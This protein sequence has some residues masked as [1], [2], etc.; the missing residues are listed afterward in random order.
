MS[1]HSVHLIGREEEEEED[2]FRQLEVDRDKGEIRSPGSRPPSVIETLLTCLDRKLTDMSQRQ[3]E[4]DRRHEQQLANISQQQSELAQQHTSELSRLVERLERVETSIHGSARGSPN[5]G[6]WTSRPEGASF[7]DAAPSASGYTLSQPNSVSISSFPDYALIPERNSPVRFEPSLNLRRSLRLLGK[8]RPDYRFL[9]GRVSTSGQ[10]SMGTMWEEVNEI[11]PEVGEGS[12]SR[13]TAEMPRSQHLGVA[14]EVAA[15]RY[16]GDEDGMFFNP[17]PNFR[18]VGFE[19]DVGLACASRRNSEIGV[20]RADKNINNAMETGRISSQGIRIGQ[21]QTFIPISYTSFSQPTSR[22]ARPWTTSVAD[23]VTN[24][25]RSSLAG[26][27]LRSEGAVK[28]PPRQAPQLRHPPSRV[29]IRPL[30]E[31]HMDIVLREP[32]TTVTYATLRYPIACTALEVSNQMSSMW[33]ATTGSQE[34]RPYGEDVR[35]PAPSTYP[36]CTSVRPNFEEMAQTSSYLSM[37]P[38]VSTATQTIDEPAILGSQLLENVA[39]PPT[40]SP[41]APPT[42][43]PLEKPRNYIKLESYSGQTPLLPFLRRFEVCSRQNQWSSSDRLNHLLCSLKDGASQL[44]WESGADEIQSAEDL[45]ERLQNRY[46]TQ[47]QQA[48]FRVQLSARRQRPG[49]DLAALFADIQRLMAL[50]YPGKSVHSETIAIQAYLGAIDDREL[51]LKVSER[52][53]AQLQE[54]YK[55]SLRLQAYKQAENDNNRD[56]PRNRGRVHAVGVRDQENSNNTAIQRLERE[57]KELKKDLRASKPPLTNNCVPNYPPPPPPAF[58]PRTSRYM[59]G[60]LQHWRRQR[61]SV[62]QPCPQCGSNAHLVCTYPYQRADAIRAPPDAAPQEYRP[63]PRP[64]FQSRYVPG[65]DS[66]YLKVALHGKTIFALLDSGS[67]TSLCPQ[68]LIRPR[69]VRPSSQS[70]IAANGTIINVAGESELTIKVDNMTFKVP[71]LIT[72]QLDD[73]I[74]GLGWMQERITSWNFKE[75]WVEMQGRRVNVHFRSEAGRCRRVATAKDVVVP[76]FSEL[77]VEAYAILPN[78]KEKPS[79]WATKASL[80]DTG[81]IVAGSL[82][83][84][85]AVDLT[86]RV[87]NPTDKA[88]QL[89]RGVRCN[90]EKVTVVEQ[91][92]KESQPVRCANIVH[93]EPVDA[94]AVLEPLWRNIAED[95]PDEIQLK[96]RNLLLEHQKAFSLAEWDLGFTDILQHEIDTGSEPPVRQALRRQPLMQLPLIDEQVDIMLKQGLIEKSCSDWASNV[97]IVT[98]KDGTPR[99]CVDYRQLNNTTRKDAYPLPLISECLDT[100]GGASWFSTFDLRAGYHQVALH[101]KDRHKTA[102]VTRG[103]SYQFRVLPFGLC[104]SPACFSRL[105]GLVMAGLNFTICLIYLDDIIVFASDLETHLERLE[106]V[107]ERLVAVNLKLNPSKCH[108]LQ[109]RVLFLGHI[110]SQEG[111]ETDPR[112]IEAV[113]SW[114]TPT[115]LKEVR[116][117]MGLCSYY[118]KFVPQFAHVGRPLHALTRK[119]VRFNWTHE[120][121]EA[122]EQLKTA[123][124]EAPVLALPLDEGQFVLD[125]DASGEAIGAVL[126]QVQEGVER[127]ICYGSRVCSLPEQNYDVTRRELLAIIYFLKL[128]RPYLLGRRFLLRTDHSALQWLRRT[129]LPIGQQARWLTTIEEFDFEVKHRA[130]ASHQNADAM[131]RR[132]HVIRVLRADQPDPVNTESATEPWSRADVA[133]EQAD[134]PELGWIIGKLKESE[135]VH[136]AQETKRQ[137]AVIKLLVAQWPQLKLLDELLVRSWLDAEDSSVRWEQIVLP[138]SRRTELIQRSHEGMTGGHLGLKRTY[139]QVQRRAYWPNWREDVRLQ[140]A[141]CEPCARYFRGKP[142]HQAPLQNMVVG[143]IGEV[144]AL[145]LTGPHVTSSQG[146]KYILTMID[147]FSRWAEAFPVRNQEA[148][149]VARVLVDQWISRYGCPLQIL[150]DQGPCLESALFADLC[151]MLDV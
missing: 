84:K 140:L 57:V 6:L 19:P 134:D 60:E 139:V 109:K 89:Q 117:F 74:L 106:L 127:V 49:E 54:A 15:D 88:I 48:L 69:D 96:L 119:D 31:P 107:L 5:P 50:A 77:E 80:L 135:D 126:S 56:Y 147:H 91:V 17:N 118:R 47:D 92:P 115:K 4:T 46:G 145:D 132:P 108:L 103:G 138:K 35:R 11:R 83:P 24:V 58:A 20:Q 149:T 142:V 105:M 136:S 30:P 38:M 44:I 87:L 45:I 51:A 94:E 104:G 61:D 27:W 62:R 67:Q 131:S 21:P 123:L 144:L 9:S 81:L 18:S 150:T 36:V 59:S 42:S 52:E 71:V 64:S 76:P 122:F 102:F 63:E 151:K 2:E 1:S 120:C 70:L 110:V 16:N 124:T 113:R 33:P 146:H 53:P 112:K 137:S 13:E 40:T 22:G 26:S 37:K 78:L 116:A 148:H 133:K 39:P 25:G 75:G 82:L 43:T 73:L 111:I 100:L 90:V 79:T 34:L 128:Y 10:T 101:P 129:P 12:N 125:T 8:P 41:P 95:V 141:R 72:P 68:K 29:N 121:D 98:K 143:E 93:P 55:L 32:P 66:G 99:F 85:R 86:L 28:E 130:G 23:V 7:I 3:F 114:P 14:P 65:S 97:V